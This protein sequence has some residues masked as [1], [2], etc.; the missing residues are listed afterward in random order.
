MQPFL[1][2]CAAYIYSI[3]ICIHTFFRL[4]R[5]EALCLIFASENFIFNSPE[6]NLACPLK[7]KTI[8][9]PKSSLKVP[10]SQKVYKMMT[11]MSEMVFWRAI[12][13]LNLLIRPCSAYR[14]NR[15]GLFFRHYFFSLIQFGLLPF[16]LSALV[17][18]AVWVT[19][20]S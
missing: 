10:N 5:L 15:V 12:L 9:T 4:D 20:K 14:Y 13:L 18:S 2:I 8:E 1:Q 3:F 6:P 19:A 7:K 11:V 17:F 16:L